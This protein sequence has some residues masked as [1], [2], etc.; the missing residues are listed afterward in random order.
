MQR[1]RD[2]MTLIEI[3]TQYLRAN[4]YDGLYHS[5]GECACE[6]GDLWPCDNPNGDCKAGH[7]V[8]CPGK[9]C[10]GSGHRHFHIGEKP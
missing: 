1:K 2:T 6:V 3:V 4:G 7:Y 10:A 5:D 8:D 9:E